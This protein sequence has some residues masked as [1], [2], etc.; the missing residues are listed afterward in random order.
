MTPSSTSSPAPGA[1]STG[2]STA[3]TIEFLA[4]TDEILNTETSWIFVSGGWGEVRLGDED[5]VADNSSV[6][7]Q[8]IAAGTGGIDGDVVDEIAVGVVYLTH[9]DTATKIR[10]YTPILRRLQRRRGLHADAGG[11]RQ[12]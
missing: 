3:A 10:Y 1:R 4:D 6:G 9:T 12:R 7:A 5:G 2:S 8:E 11:G